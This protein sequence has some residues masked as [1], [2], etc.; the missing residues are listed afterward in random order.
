MSQRPNDEWL[1]RIPRKLAALLLPVFGL[2][3]LG[4]PLVMWMAW[5]PEILGYGLAVGVGSL[6]VAAVL[7]AS[8]APREVDPAKDAAW[9]SAYRKIVEPE[10]VRSRTWRDGA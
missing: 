3:A 1:D 9:K 8:L 6:F 5:E 2:M 4:T 7:G 10:E